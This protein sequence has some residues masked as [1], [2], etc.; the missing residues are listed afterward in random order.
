MARADATCLRGQVLASIAR[1]SPVARP[2]WSRAA[3]A[4]IMLLGMAS[5]PAAMAAEPDIASLERE[6]AALKEVVQRLQARVDSLER[7]PI[8]AEQPASSVPVAASPPA[9]QVASRASLKAALPAAPIAALQPGA[10][11]LVASPEAQLR[12]NW[13]KIEPGIDAGQVSRLLGEPTKKLR[14][15]GRNAWYYSYPAMGNGS[16]FFTDAGRVSSR[17]SP[18]GWGG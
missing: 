3:P 17:Q 8:A 7:H 5:L 1:R 15:D 14:L 10:D 4:W 9:S 13:S 11:P 16:V 18:F 2:G 6:V 12:A